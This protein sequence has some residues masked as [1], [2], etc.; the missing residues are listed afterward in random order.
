VIRL[1]AATNI[2]VGLIATLV[3]PVS[4]VE[5][6]RVEYVQHGRLAGLYVPYAHRL[7]ARAGDDQPAVSGRVGR[8]DILLVA[9]EDV[10][11]AILW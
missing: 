2:L 5:W 11:N 4:R 9:V 8:V 3:T 6:V 10:L 1:P 7:V